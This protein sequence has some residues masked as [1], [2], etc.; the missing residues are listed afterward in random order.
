MG[1]T[2]EIPV[3]AKVWDNVL[4]MV[5]IMPKLELFEKISKGET[6]NEAQASQKSETA[7]FDNEVSGNAFEER[8]KAI[9]AKLNGST[10]NNAT[11]S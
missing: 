9:K 7:A 6:V 11:V 8:S 3:D 1:Q 10:N 4:K 5:E 2:P